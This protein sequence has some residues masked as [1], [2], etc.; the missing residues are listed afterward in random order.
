MNSTDT[1]ALG[2][3]RIVRELSEELIGPRGGEKEVIER[4]RP[5]MRY[6]MGV[7]FPRSTSLEDLGE[8]MEAEEDLEGAEPAPPKAD[9]GRADDPVTLSGQW[10][11]ASLGLSFYFTDAVSIE[12][13][14]W[15]AAYDKGEG[16]TWSRV[17]LAGEDDPESHTVAAPA[18]GS[19]RPG[20]L[21]VL[22]GRAELHSLWR[23]IDDGYLVTVTLVNAKIKDENNKRPRARDCVYQVG[24]RCSVPDGEVREYPSVDR[25]MAGEEERELELLYRGKRTYA[26]GHGCAASW[27]D[28]GERKSVK[29]ELLPTAVVP[30][31]THTLADSDEE[32]PTALR[33]SFLADESV[34]TERLCDELE[35]FLER[36]EAWIDALS[37]KHNDIPA[38][39]LPARNRLLRRLSKTSGRMRKGVKRLRTDEQARRAFRL[40]NRAMLMQ[41]HRGGKGNAGTRRRRNRAPLP[42]KDFDYLSLHNY[43]WRPFQLAFQLLTMEGLCDRE[44]PERDLVDLIWFPTGGGKTEA[45]LAVAAFE[46][47]RRRLVHGEAGA[48]TA[49]ITRYTLRLLTSQQFQRS[50]RL[51]CALELLRR[52]SPA[53]LGDT[54]VTVGFWAGGSTSPNRFQYAREKRLEIIEAGGRNVFQL[55][56]CPWCGTEIIPENRTDDEEAYG[57]RADNASFQMFCPTEGCVFHDRLPISVVDEHLYRTPP[58]FL[59]GTVDKFALLAWKSGGGAFFGREGVLPPT[60]VIQDELHLLSGPLGTTTAVYEAALHELMRINGRRPKVVASTATIRSASD[61]VGSLFNRDVHLFPPA[62]LEADDSFFSRVDPE[63]PGRLYAGI[64]SSHHKPST[65]L[66]RTASGLLQAPEEVPLTEVEDDVYRTLVIYHLSLRELGKT[67]AFATDDIPARLRVIAPEGPTRRIAGVV[68]LTSNTPS[69]DIPA[70]L[71]R[72]ERPPGHDRFIDVL[73]CTNM[74]SVGVDVDRLGLMIVNGQPKTTSEYIQA[75]SRVGRKHPGLVIAHYSANKPRDRSHYEDFHAYHRSLYRR[76]EP[77][78]VTPFSAPSRDRALH[79][80]LVLLV[81]HE[82]GL[83]LDE[84][85]ARFDPE[86]PCVGSVVNSLLSVIEEIDPDEITAA[87]KQLNQLIREWGELAETYGDTLRYDARRDGPQWQSLLK[88]FGKRG[89]GWGTLYSMRSVD[90]ESP[91]RIDGANYN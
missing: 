20:P 31:I 77:T 17:P 47:V 54:P 33:I 8:D 18:D 75:S 58:T 71:E 55:E 51:I 78:S 30:D 37:D 15:G 32:K 23:R 49:V 65:S 60:L 80:A 45:Y 90:G 22:G 61:Q 85:A 28:A 64:M 73:I 19:R 36:Y 72:L 52:R 68:E 57:V 76:V 26:V 79:A 48:G 69:S 21:T 46:I 1:E 35:S 43:A 34:S 10:M 67:S 9:E 86:S 66:V 11:P 74:I 3:D 83:D 16:R 39:L 6:T 42:P 81:R 24:F 89:E 53:E 62:G 59:I 88:P 14:V 91:M 56:R 50:A 2:R 29:T 44:S 63:A 5:H 82:C 70:V 27:G 38:R 84:D 7:L 40:A 13:D 4:E 12:V 41:M 25:A 87:E